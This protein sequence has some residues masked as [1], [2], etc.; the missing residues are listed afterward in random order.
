MTNTVAQAQQR[1]LITA[2]HHSEPWSPDEVELLLDNLNERDEDLAYVLGRSLYAVTSKTY[3][4]RHG[5]TSHSP[6]ARTTVRAFDRGYVDIE[7]LFA[8]D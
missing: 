7:A 3:E 5:G 4:L 1:T 8:G 2:D 6:R